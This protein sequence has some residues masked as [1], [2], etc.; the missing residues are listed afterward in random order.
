MRD[1]SKTC[2]MQM[3]NMNF[4]FIDRRVPFIRRRLS[5]TLLS[6]EHTFWS[7]V[8]SQSPY[9]IYFKLRPIW[10]LNRA[11]SYASTR[12]WF[13]LWAV[14]VL[15]LFK[16][17]HS[18]TR[19]KIFFFNLSDATPKLLTAVYGVC[20]RGFRTRKRVERQHWRRGAKNVERF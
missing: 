6:T 19:G 18:I 2:F 13:S 16:Y 4:V 8:F 7:V 15:I 20:W 5:H 3:K 17:C 11:G 14:S 12:K 1:V 9:Y 10:K